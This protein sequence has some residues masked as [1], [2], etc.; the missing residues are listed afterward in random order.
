MNSDGGGAEVKAA[1]VVESAMDAV[2]LAAPLTASERARFDTVYRL[3]YEEVL[4][5]LRRRLHNPDD[6]EELTQE[7]YLRILRYRD[8]GPESLKLLLF[9]T[10]LNLATSHGTCAHA[11]AKHV[12]LDDIEIA[13]DA[14]SMEDEVAC[15][16]RMRQLMA[17]VDA[18]PNR[19]RQVF[20]LR[21]AHGLRQHEIAQRCGISTR[22][23]EQHLAR[24]QVL[25]RERWA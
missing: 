4:R 18:L 6:A 11:R 16:Q 8:C 23:V 3:H 19:C 17:V 21:L 5:L 7:A 1:A 25:I 10:A 13:M 24:A 15:D 22:R 20:L 2:S 12:S 9:R 14:R